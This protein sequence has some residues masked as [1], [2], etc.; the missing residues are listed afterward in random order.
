MGG[1]DSEI[2]DGTTTVALEVAW[3]E[4]LGIAASATRTGLRSDASNRFERDVDPYSIDLAIARFAELLAE[5]CPDLVV[6]AGAC[7]CPG[8][9]AATG[10][11]VV[12]GAGEPGESDPRHRAET[13]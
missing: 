9:V 7:R 3:F 5:T 13:R 1:A 11:S 4:P 2:A 12:P 6:H 8:R 10:G